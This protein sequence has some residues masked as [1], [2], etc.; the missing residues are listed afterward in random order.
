MSEDEQRTGLTDDE[1][2]KDDV[3]AHM[4]GG[5]HIAGDDGGSDDVHG[6]MKGGRH[7]DGDDDG[8]DVTAHVKLGKE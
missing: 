3:D 4:R 8:D 7:M 1:G 6:H 5:R 2:A